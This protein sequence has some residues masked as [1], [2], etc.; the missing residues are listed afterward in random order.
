MNGK[1]VGYM[2]V[3]TLDQNEARQ[4]EGTELDKVFI[5]KASGG[6]TNRPALQDCLTYLREGDTLHVHSIDRLARNLHDLQ[7]TVSGLLE[8]GI[9]VTFH[10]ENLSFFAGEA[11]NPCQEL[12]LQMLGAFAQFEL[13]MIRERQ[14]EG[15]EAAKKAGKKLG[16]PGLDKA[17]AAQIRT[18]REAGQSAIAIAKELG[19]SRQTVYNVIKAQ[20]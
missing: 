6:T 16:R 8:A 12:M 11:A 20:I 13:S 5:D 15:I 1:H 19:L 2:R 18:L 4:L 10:K 7:K 14:R 17:L 9:S 3:S